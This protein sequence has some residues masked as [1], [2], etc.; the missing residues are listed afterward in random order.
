MNNGTIAPTAVEFSIAA[1]ESGGNTGDGKYFYAFSPRLIIATTSPTR[2]SFDLSEETDRR[3]TIEDL[4]ST[5]S[6][7]QIGRASITKDGR[8]LAITNQN[9]ER[10]L[11][12]MSL[13]VRDHVTNELI[14]CD[15]QMTNVPVGG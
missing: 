9:T 4:V 11:I 1:V 7:Y 3:F 10:T 2:V 8:A 5:D 14:N 12:F 15:P 6:K 13:L